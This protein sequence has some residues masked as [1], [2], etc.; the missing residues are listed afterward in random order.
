MQTSRPPM[1]MPI[2]RALVEITP[3]ILP[4]AR[5]RFDLPA[6]L[7]QKPGPVGADVAAHLRRQALSDQTWISSVSLRAWVKQ[8]VLRPSRM[9]RAK[10]WA[11]VTGAPPGG[12]RNRKCRPDWGAPLSVMISTSRPVKRPDKNFG[13]GDGG[14]GQ[15]K[16]RLRAVVGADAPQ[17]PQHLGHVAAHDAPVGVDFVDDHELEPGK[18]AGPGGVVGHQPHMQHVRVADEHVG[19]LAP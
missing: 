4:L 13:L 19:R 18:E 3:C 1:S 17:A 8:M 14:G 11:A 15:D 6:L 16:L 5:A 9:A 2:S 12:L 7:R 10:I